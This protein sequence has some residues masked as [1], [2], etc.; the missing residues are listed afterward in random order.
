MSDNWGCLVYFCELVLKVILGVEY[1]YS[2]VELQILSK[3]RSEP[4]VLRG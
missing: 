4:K 2:S 3:E 1:D